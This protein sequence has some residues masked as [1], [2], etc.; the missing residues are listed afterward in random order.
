M[1]DLCTGDKGA[2]GYEGAAGD[3]GKPVCIKIIY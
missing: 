1:Y 3:D 2:P